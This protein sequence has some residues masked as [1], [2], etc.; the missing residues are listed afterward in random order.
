MS[1]QEEKAM[2]V[3]ARAREC[4][5]IQLGLYKIVRVFTPGRVPVRGYGRPQ[6]KLRC[7]HMTEYLYMV[8]AVSVY[9]RVRMP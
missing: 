5:W 3:R 7:L 1:S 9:R 4:M 2:C 8:R 6:G